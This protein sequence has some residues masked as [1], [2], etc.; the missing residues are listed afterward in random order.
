[1]RSNLTYGAYLNICPFTGLVFLDGFS[2]DVFTYENITLILC[3]QQVRGE[4]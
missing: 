4:P 3:L 1:M 2:R